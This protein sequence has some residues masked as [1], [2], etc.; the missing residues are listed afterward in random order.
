MVDIVST[1]K[2]AW[3]FTLRDFA[4]LYAP[5]F[6]ISVKKMMK[7]LWGDHYYSHTHKQWYTTP[8][9]ASGHVLERAFNTLIYNVLYRIYH[10]I[11]D[12]TSIQK[13]CNKIH[14]V[15]TGMTLKMNDILNGDMSASVRVNALLS[16]WLP[17]HA[18]LLSLIINI[19]PSP[20][21]AQ[22]YRAETL[23][24]SSMDDPTAMAIKQCDANGPLVVYIAKLIPTHDN[25]HFYAF[26]RVYSGSIK[27]GM[28]V[29]ILNDT[30]NP[31]NE[32][33][34]DVHI[35]NIA[36]VH[37]MM[38]PYVEKS[39]T[40]L[41]AGNMIGI[42]G[43]DEYIGKQATIV[44]TCLSRSFTFNPLSFSVSPVVRCGVSVSNP[45]HLSKLL[46]G[47]S[48]LS[49]SDPLVQIITTHTGQHIIAAAGEL[50]L[51]ICI[52]DLQEMYMGA[53]TPIITEKPIVS[54]CET[55]MNESTITVCSKSANKHNRVYMTAT[56]LHT[57]LLSDIDAGIVK[58]YDA[59]GY[60]SVD[61]KALTRT[62]NGDYHFNLTDAKKLW[63]YSSSS[64]CGG[65]N[66]LI[67][68]TKSVQY[69]SDIQDMCVNA[70][71]ETMCDRGGVLC[72][73][74]IRGVRMDMMDVSL[75]SDKVHRN[76]TAIAPMITRAIYASLLTAQPTLF[77]PMYKCIIQCDTHEGKKG[78]YKTLHMHQGEIIADDDDS[79]S[80]SSSSAHHSNNV[81]TAYIPVAS[82]FGFQRILSEN[83]CG[84][85]SA[86]LVFSHW[87]RMEYTC[88]S[89][90]YDT[91]TPIGTIIKD[92]RMRK[93]LPPNVPPLSNF[94]DHI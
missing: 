9:D 27:T 23:Y 8:V 64:I 90:I 87:K 88:T 38:G 21:Q 16:T 91:H 36:S 4:L 39:L 69:L 55:V 14:S 81:I 66:A 65:M 83:T 67:D 84:S 71:N 53:D 68:S 70:F 22:S 63:S 57:Q 72:G 31:L 34:G 10:R 15:H 47:L 19:L 2:N 37:I 77:Q 40:H 59:N 20:L 51:E 41:C 35:V 62:L 52:K 74:P 61:K 30:Y 78:A 93:G 26:G 79:S 45:S 76:I 58:L 80:S 60:T 11:D 3:G 17:C 42:S 86:A 24:N 73:E 44:D 75:H 50:H 92:I 46:H 33:K 13:I 82:S 48:R 1:G 49:K 29:R 94:H 28:S 25:K 18:C 56:P 54:Y 85:A 6:N 12:A 7:K 32:R 5:Q 43:I 89:D